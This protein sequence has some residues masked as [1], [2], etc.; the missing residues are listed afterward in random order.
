MRTS[1]A[2]VALVM[3]AALVAS[4]GRETPTDA[5]FRVTGHA[6]A[7]PVCPVQQDPPDPA[8]ADK[9]VAGATLVIVDET[10]EEV[11]AIQTDTAGNFGATLPAGN[12]TLVPQPVDG[13]LGTAPP[14]TFTTGRGLAPALDVAYDTGIR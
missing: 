7:G 12:Y 5:A 3:L 6:H 9:P 10:G 11:A 13:L 1:I 4:C 8:C 2:A 14:Q